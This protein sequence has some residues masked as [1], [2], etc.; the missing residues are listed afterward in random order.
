MRSGSA[1]S[2]ISPESHS[3]QSLP[4]S[5]VCTLVNNGRRAAAAA[6]ASSPHLTDCFCRIPNDSCFVKPAATSVHSPTA[7]FGL[8]DELAQV[9]AM[10]ER[11]TR[12]G[13]RSATRRCL[14]LA[15]QFCRAIHTMWPW[16]LWLLEP[17]SLKILAPPL[18]ATQCTALKRVWVSPGP[19]RSRQR[20]GRDAHLA[21]W[22][23]RRR[24]SKSEWRP[25]ASYC[26]RR[27]PGWG[28][29]TRCSRAASGYPMGRRPA[30]SSKQQTNRPKRSPCPPPPHHH[31]HNSA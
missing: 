14:L 2:R 22:H 24:A 15:L 26:H 31:T 20:S 13:S 21:K 25:R 1:Q 27:C 4:A 28:P 9:L 7:A 12:D 30:N 5:H 3:C 10:E 29:C 19:R 23:S 6:H 17:W 11:E 8:V 18:K 16:S